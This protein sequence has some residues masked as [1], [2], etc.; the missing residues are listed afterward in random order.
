MHARSFLAHGLLVAAATA[1]VPAN[2][3]G[4]IR[5]QDGPVDDGTVADCTWYDTAVDS[6][7]DCA[8]FE[9]SWS[10][11][12]AQFVAYVSYWPP[13]SP[14]LICLSSPLADACAEPQRQG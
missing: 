6:S 1:A 11:T 3:H 2:R 14:Y 7:Y 13:S 8:Y 4:H 12:H 10:M 9:E 5:R